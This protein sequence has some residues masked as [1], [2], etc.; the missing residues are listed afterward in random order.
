MV[1]AG[2]RNLFY[3][4][5]E[6]FS[7]QQHCCFVASKMFTSQCINLLDF[8]YPIGN[9]PAVSLTQCLP[10][11]IPAKILLLGCGDLRNILFTTHLD[12]ELSSNQCGDVYLDI[13]R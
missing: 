11:K 10:S 3:H 9:T 8:F 12:G 5:V 6:P 2:I 4:S 13:H 7:P 1:A